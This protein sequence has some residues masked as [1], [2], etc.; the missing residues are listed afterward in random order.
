MFLRGGVAAGAAG[1][2]AAAAVEAVGART[3]ETAGDGS[4]VARASV[5]SLVAR[6]V[7]DG[8]RFGQVLVSGC[9]IRRCGAGVGVTLGVGGMVVGAAAAAT[10]DGAID[11]ASALSAPGPGRTQSITSRNGL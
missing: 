6:G 3:G 8:K 9:A 11:N 4:A 1:A 10:V 2:D 7:P 5:S